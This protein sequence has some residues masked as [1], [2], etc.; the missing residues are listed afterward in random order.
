M[1]RVFSYSPN[2]W[3]SNVERDLPKL[4]EHIKAAWDNR[5]TDRTYMQ[6]L[7][8]RK[9]RPVDGSGGQQ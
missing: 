2:L 4:S 3:T 6:I 9:R 5:T 7:T 1:M 8:G